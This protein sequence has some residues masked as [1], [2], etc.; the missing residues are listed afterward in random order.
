[1]TLFI[2]N[3]E[4]ILF[5]HV[6]KCGGSSIAKLFKD[7]GYSP[8]MEMRG[9]PPQD[10][11]TASPQHQTCKNLR[12]MMNME[13]LD[14]IFIMARNPYARIRSEFNW[15]FRSTAP[16]DRP[17]INQWTIE[18][19]TKATSDGDHADNHFRTCIDFIDEDLPCRIFK[20]EDGINFMI[21]FFL[22]KSNSIDSISIPTEK[23]AKTFAS[24]LEKLQLNDS[25]IQAINQ[26][27]K[28]DFKAFGY[29]PITSKESENDTGRFGRHEKVDGHKLETK[30]KIIREWR[31]ETLNELNLKVQSELQLICKRLNNSSDI[32]ANN[33]CVQHA[34]TSNNRPNSSNNSYDGI[35]SKIGSTTQM[36]KL[37]SSSEQEDQSKSFS[38]AQGLIDQCNRL[39]QNTQAENIS[40]TIQLLE[41]YRGILRVSV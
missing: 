15:H 13:K 1:M 6:P 3:E 31:R 20:I 25:T 41:H 39:W 14:S 5:L 8:A 18:S 34:A 11:L 21:E 16:E 26:F 38:E 2:Q 29:T 22:R 28:Y 23:N 10:C 32:H 40:K 19:L 4:S 24:P 33:S 17:D 9:L 30:A 7:N 35:L 12:P 36:I 27:Y 37:L